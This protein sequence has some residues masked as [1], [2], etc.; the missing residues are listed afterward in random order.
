MTSSDG[1]RGHRS[2]TGNNNSHLFIIN[3]MS[4][5]PKLD[6]LVTFATKFDIEALSETWLEQSYTD[7]DL[8]ILHYTSYLTLYRE[9]GNRH[10]GGATLHVINKL[11]TKRHGPRLVDGPLELICVDVLSGKKSCQVGCVYRRLNEAISWYDRFQSVL[12]VYCERRYQSMII[13]GDFNCDFLKSRDSD[14]LRVLMSM[15]GMTQSIDKPTRISGTTITT[16]TTSCRWYNVG[17]TV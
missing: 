6:I 2:S 10:G 11:G 13:L 15:Y 7:D 16:K 4:L 9:D 17:C 8:N 5:P 3:V 12:D 14:R 1:H